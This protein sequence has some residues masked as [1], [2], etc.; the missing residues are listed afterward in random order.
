MIYFAGKILMQK[1]QSNLGIKKSA[2]CLSLLCLFKKNFSDA[3]NN[4]KVYFLYEPQKCSHKRWLEQAY[5]TNIQAFVWCTAY[6]Q[7]QPMVWINM[8]ATIRL[9]HS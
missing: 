3:R 9:L 7:I 5:N 8:P 6:E 2:G 4:L 1:S